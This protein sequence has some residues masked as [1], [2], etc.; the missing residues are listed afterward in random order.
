MNISIEPT[1][2]LE[3]VKSVFFAPNIYEHGCDDECL[4]YRASMETFDFINSVPGFFL[5]VLVDGISAGLFWGI[6]DG[7]AVDVHVALLPNCRGNKAVEAGKQFI[8]WVL[9]HTK[10]ETIKAGVWSDSPTVSWL[11]RSVGMKPAKTI[12]WTNLRG[13]KPVDMTYFIFNRGEPI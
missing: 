1:S 8:R 12:P 2:D 3:Y 4:K 13:G 9:S 6:W 7:S 10:A 11:C 5:K